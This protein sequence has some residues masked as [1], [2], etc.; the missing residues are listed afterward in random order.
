MCTLSLVASLNGACP[1]YPVQAQPSEELVEA[2]RLYDQSVKL[3]EASQYREAQPLAERA[4]AIRTKALGEKH[5][6]VAQSLHSLGNLYLKQGNYAGAEPLYRRALAIREKALG[7][8]H[9]EVARSLNSLAVLYIDRGNYAGAES[10]HKRA[11]AIRE[12]ALGGEHPDV[13]QTL[14]NLAALHAERGDYTEAGLLFR[15]ALA[16]LE[17]ALGP[18]HPEVAR[19]L[20]NLAALYGRLGDY[21][22]AGLLFR[23]ALAL[24]E[25]A[26]G[27]DHP[28]VARSLNNLATLYGR[29]GDYTKAE[30]LSQR[31]LSILEKALGTE[32]PE[33]GQ[34]LVNLA[35]PRRKRGDYTEAEPLIRRA[36]LLREKFLGPE[37]PDVAT[38]FEELALLRLG[39]DRLDDARQALQKAID[40]QEQNLALNLSSTSQSQN[41][42][43]LATLKDTAD[44][45]LWLHLARLGDDPEAARLAL[46]AA[47]S[48][49]GRVLEEATLALARLRRRLPADRQQP[50]QQLADARAQLASLVFQESGPL[51]SEQYQARVGE[52]RQRVRRLEDGLEG[53]G[54][55][56]RMLTRPLSLQAV[57][58]A[59]PKD[60]VLVEFVLYRP[61]D[62]KA[63]TPDRQFGASRYAAYLLR[64]TGAP[65]G[66]DL[67]DARQIDD[68]VTAWHSWLLDPTSP[69]DGPVHKLARLLHQKLLAPLG[70]QLQA[71]H[72]LIAPDGQLNTLPF[73]ALVGQD[74]HPL[75]QDHTLTYLV[76]GRELPR[77]AQASSAPR[78]A[79]LVL[80][81]PDFARAAAGLSPA[82][83][84]RAGPDYGAETRLEE[85]L[86]S[87]ALTGF[88]VRPLPGA[89]VEA[90]AV[91]RLLGIP[92]TELLTGARATE[93]ALK[94]TRSPA[95]LHLA[96]HGFFLKDQGG[97]E[98]EI[99]LQ[100]PLLRSGVALAG[101]NARSSGTEDGVLTA[102]E[103][104][105]LDL[106]GTELAVVSACQSGAGAVVGG[107][108]VQ[109]L[110]RALALA[111]TRSQVLALWPVG[112]RTTADL[113]E[114]FYRRLAAG[115]GRSEAL[116]QAQLAVSGQQRRSHPFW[117]ASFAASGDWRPVQL[118]QHR[119]RALLLHEFGTVHRANTFETAKRTTSPTKSRPSSRFQE[120][121]PWEKR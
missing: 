95:L 104:Q 81:G 58:Q 40:I 11:L 7:P 8:N 80:G 79:P 28:E 34:S 55:P 106:E 113:M 108:G 38:G 23:R 45:A 20:N 118:S 26:L 99:G 88:T 110:R 42:A 107:E 12:K 89:K 29:L 98:K 48:R 116:R 78:S 33:V 84:Q 87:P 19:G 75:L 90:A 17:K 54:G 68:L 27:P 101:F 67:G 5:L 119:R 59:L 82:T 60:A 76:S 14:N 36:L 41:Q 39:Q 53:T 44:F 25:K 100:E 49:K 112:D 46:T 71:K 52:L 77:L 97:A 93:N 51:P 70:S 6:E 72:L 15:R 83:Q 91:A 1:F 102:L 61:F 94:A 105:G 109:G 69:V 9:P 65:L 3:W 64:P 32:H 120:A 103:A 22:E 31:A 86:R 56:L 24:L 47:L 115:A 21:T 111:G 92:S 117:W 43:Y 114:R 18:D 63:A 4:L 50:L 13:I 73:A 37:H 2:Q 62:A 35:I 16:L 121:I 74:G 96:T 66:V 10:L 57:Q 85:N 30:P